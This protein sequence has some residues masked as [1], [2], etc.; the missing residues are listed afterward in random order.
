MLPKNLRLTNNSAF[1]A[2][3]HAKNSV[4]DSLFIVFAGKLKK[5][6]D[7]PT[8]AGFVVSKKNHKRAVKRNRLKRLMRESYKT[9][10]KENKILQAQNFMSIVIVARNA[11]IGKDFYSIKSSIIS[12]ISKLKINE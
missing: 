11:A 6:E 4:S 2:T 10:I 5:S 9:A 12:L 3:Y 1:K 8:R 7:F